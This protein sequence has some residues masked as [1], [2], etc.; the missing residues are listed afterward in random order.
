MLKL[1][2]CCIFAY[3]LFFL[4]NQFHFSRTLTFIWDSHRD[5]LSKTWSAFQ[6]KR[7]NLFRFC[8]KKKVYRN[9]LI[10]RKSKTNIQFFGCL[11]KRTLCLLFM[12]WFWI[13]TSLNKQPTNINSVLNISRFYDSNVRRCPIQ[14][15]QYQMNL[16]NSLE[17]EILVWIFARPL[18]NCYSRNAMMTYHLIMQIMKMKIQ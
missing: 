12:Q 1:S 16:N 8:R 4:F 14:I 6:D 11:A 3:K 13:K 10:G 9:I 2:K 5:M 17:Y 7:Q 15:F 18:L